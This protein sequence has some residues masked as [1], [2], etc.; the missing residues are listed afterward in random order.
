[1]SIELLQTLD[2]HQ[3]RVWSLGWNP[4]GT[5]FASCGGDKLIKIWGKEG[6]E[7]V[8][9]S[10][11]SD[12][13]NRTVRSVSWSPCGNLLAAASFDAT[14]SIW[15]KSSS[16]FECTSTLEGHDNEVKSAAWSV[17]GSYLA[18]CSRD[19]T[20]WIWEVDED[21]YECAS[22]LNKHTQ[23]VKKI[24]WHPNIDIFASCSYDDTISIF[25]ED[26]DDWVCCGTLSGHSS[27]V[28]SLAFDK[29]GDRLVTCSD[30]RTIKI[31]QCYYPN[32]DEGVVTIGN[33]PTW[34]CVCTLSGYHDRPIY[35]VDWS[36]V[37]GLIVSAGGDDCINVF[38][39]D[40]ENSSKNEPCFRLLT[41]MQSAH[42]QDV[43]CVKWNPV[44]SS[45]LTTCSDDM[46]IKVWT[47]SG[48]EL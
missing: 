34:K 44:D 12:H 23:D 18:T 42:V 47:V 46:S 10:S 4:K 5:L 37:S 15:D 17:S 16:E 2:S 28:W 27:T 31:W 48:F 45:M 41:S 25:K 8:C 3:E 32:N 26:D 14:V 35:D 30:D 24:A 22:V 13:H 20:V 40:I 7:W 33:D 9:K 38:Q 6:G 39:E 19:K 43:N 1:M 11:L 36:H 29:T 21:E